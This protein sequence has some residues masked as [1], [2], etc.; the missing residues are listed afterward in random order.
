MRTVIRQQAT[1]GRRV[2]ALGLWLALGGC[3]QA[4][5]FVVVDSRLADT[6]YAKA[7]PLPSSTAAYPTRHLN[8]ETRVVLR[9]ATEAEQLGRMPIRVEADVPKGGVLEFG[10]GLAATPE[11]PGVE[12]MVSASSAGGSV[13][14]FRSQLEPQHDGQADG[15]T[16]H[17]ARV[18]LTGLSGPVTFEFSAASSRL[19]TETRKD[20]VPPFGFFSEPVITRAGGDTPPLHVVL[21]SLDT[22]RADR[23]GIYGYQRGTSP[24]IDRIFGSRGIVLERFYSNAVTTLYAHAAMMTGVLP[25]TALTRNRLPRLLGAWTTTLAESF[26]AA[27]FRTA[28]F[29]E[30]GFVAATFGFWR[31]METYSEIRGGGAGEDD[32]LGHAETIF[33]QGLEWMTRH[34]QE[35]TF[36]FL[37]TY[38]VHFPYTPKAKVTLTDTSAAAV[39]SANYDAE[40]RETDDLFGQF[41]AALE[42]R[43]LLDHTVI[44]VTSDHG[45]E[46]GEHG[47]R[48]HGANLYQET[49]HVPAL[50]FAPGRLP[51]GVRRRGPAAIVD[52]APTI[53]ELGGIE[54][55]AGLDGSSFVAHLRDGTGVA[56]EAIYHETVTPVSYTYEGKDESWI[57]LSYGVTTWP[58]RLTRI[59]VPEGA[60]YQLFDLEADPGERTNIYDSMK[61][62]V[63]SE[64][65]S[66]DDY[67]ELRDAQ[68]KVL[69]DRI[70]QAQA[71]A[72]PPEIDPKVNE[73]LKA[74]GYLE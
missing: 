7:A 8:S 11:T 38:Q 4:H 22:L 40:I 34:R 60:R 39:D 41:F 37:H 30:D 73:K 5:E 56:P 57:P 29:T 42:H 72:A 68:R 70:N 21:L 9:G 10:Y 15:R 63:A 59:R 36:L 51:Q 35:P 71:E 2:V 64:R 74:L 54:R 3:R 1:R 69:V 19:A 26:R 14:L 43:G 47:K 16:W 13:E 23:L 45:E 33:A 44:V 67:V 52:L 25:E 6:L 49:L 62:R 65:E 53:L 12:F 66:L 46:F 24:N 31:G 18:E 28:A 55:R 27:G 17:D 20:G 48:F 58:Y 50:F 61:A 32:A